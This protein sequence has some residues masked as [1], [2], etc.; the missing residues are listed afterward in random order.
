MR[1]RRRALRHQAG[2]HLHD[3]AH[4]AQGAGLR[5]RARG[6][7]GRTLPALEGVVAGSPHYLAPEQLQAGEP[8]TRA[9]TCTRWAWCCTSCSP[10]ARPSTA[11]RCEQIRAGGRACT[12]G[13]RRTSC[14]PDVPPSCRPSR[15][16]HGAR[17]GRSAIASARQMA[18][19]L[20]HVAG[21]AGLPTGAE[22]TEPATG[23]PPSR[24]AAAAHRAP[25]AGLG[26]AV[27]AA[28][29]WQLLALAPTADTV[30][31]AGRR[32][33]PT[34]PR[35]N[36]AAGRKPPIR[37]STVATPT[38]RQ[39]RRRR[40]RRRNAGAPMPPR[41]AVPTA[42]P[43]APRPHSAAKPVARE[44]G[45]AR[46]EPAP[47]R[48]RGHRAWCSI[49]IS[50]WGQVEVNGAP[51]GTTPPLTRLDAAEGTHT[52]HRAQRGLP[53]ATRRRVQVE[54]IS[55]SPSSIASDH[56]AQRRCTA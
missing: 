39:R 12:T 29:G 50:P 32:S 4:E 35:G 23:D 22:S 2:Q 17:P 1:K 38:A 20:R 19:A 8:S 25:A 6:A 37:G 10:A 27:G 41:R 26:A 36:R 51:A 45:A 54:P 3:R 11:T 44:P 30:A 42:A 21:A 53:A 49:A 28:A 13:H 33:P 15:A 40:A 5:H 43:P 47:R 55:P 24:R 52:D 7:P 48:C 56:E 31:R 46:D 14:D 34:A 9:P 18:Q 16:R